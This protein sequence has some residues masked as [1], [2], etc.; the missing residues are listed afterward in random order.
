MRLGGVAQAV[1][2][3]AGLN[4]SEPVRRVQLLER[5]HETRKVKNYGY[6]DALAGE[7][8]TRATGK[9]GGAGGA[10]SG[11]R[12]LNVGRVAR[13]DDADGELAVVRCIRGVKSA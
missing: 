1:K 10:A 8:G 13:I 7:T 9:N 3:D 5:I 6:V 12:S 11:Q 2:N 4:A